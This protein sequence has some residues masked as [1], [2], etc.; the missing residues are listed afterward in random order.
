AINHPDHRDTQCVRHFFALDE[1]AVQRGI[2]CAAPDGKVVG[3]GHHWPPFDIGAA[4]DQVARRKILEL[5]LVIIRPAPGNLASF[6]KRPRIPNPGNPR[7][8]TN[9]AAPMLARYFPL[10]AHF[11]RTPLALA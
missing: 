9:L 2:G 4:K 6:A 5:A 7:P 8:R 1:L 11:L 3:A 10:P